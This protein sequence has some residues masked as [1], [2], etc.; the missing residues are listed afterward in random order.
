MKKPHK[1][2]IHVGAR[3]R[4]RR[5]QLAVT[6]EELGATVGVTFQQIQKYEQG[7]HRVSSSRLYEIAK[8]LDVPVSYF[9]ERMPLNALS[10]RPAGRIRK[11]SG[12]A[13]TEFEQEEDPLIKRESLELVRAYYEIRSDRVR[14]RIFEMIKAEGME[15][16]P[17][18]RGSRKKR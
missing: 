15:R 11:S 12:D 2:D 14:Q 16:R 17:T 5:I 3:I 10:G 7:S 4:R 1:V 13:G 9:F 8:A 18:M 6:Q